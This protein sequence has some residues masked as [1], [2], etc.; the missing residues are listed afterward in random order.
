MKKKC[1]CIKNY[2]GIDKKYPIFYQGDTYEYTDQKFVTREF[3]EGFN[4]Q[5]SK[6]EYIYFRTH[7]DPLAERGFGMFST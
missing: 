5:F 7:Q 3:P 2:Y 4:V 1:T 6:G